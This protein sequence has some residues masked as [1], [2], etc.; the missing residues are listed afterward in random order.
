M[1]T[2]SSRLPLPLVRLDATGGDRGPTTATAQIRLTI[3]G[4][5]VPLEITVP[6]GP[7]QPRD[8]LPIFQGLAGVVVGLAVEEVER[9]GQSVSCR[10][11]CGACCR[12]LVPVAESEAVRLANLVE[13][14]PEPR[15]TQIQERFAAAIRR[16][17]AG[18]VAERLRDREGAEP[19]RQ[20]GLAYFALGVACPFLEEEACSIHPDRPLACREYLVTSPAE[21]CAAPTAATVRP[22]PLPAGVAGAARALDRTA[23]EGRAPW[24]PLVLAPEW[25]AAH[26]E[27]AAERTGPA[28]LQ[29]FF[30][31]LLGK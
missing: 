2:D 30:G 20:L 13:A 24:V 4:R 3:A 27:Q 5:P 25:A 23:G 19:L 21:A 12:Q 17:E 29:E 14:L 16:L 15:R 26:L 6:Q 8:L 22:V 10:K 31:R 7:V 28:L 1:P 11:G 9:Q 18:G